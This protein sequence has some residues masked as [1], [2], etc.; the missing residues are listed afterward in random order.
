MSHRASHVRP[1]FASLAAIGAIMALAGAASTAQ[2]GPG[3]L[4]ADTENH[5]VKPRFD[6]PAER[7]ASP[8][9]LHLR[10]AVIDTAQARANF[11]A[12]IE[13][14]RI[15]GVRR[16]IQLDGPMTKARRAQL[17]AAGL[18]IGAYVPSNAF[19]VSA[20]EADAQAI[21]DIDFIRWYGVY[22][23]DWKL[24]PALDA[25]WARSHPAAGIGEAAVIV[26]LFANADSD[27]FL[28]S[29]D[30]F[31]GAAALNGEM[32]GDNFIA[33]VV[34][35]RDD[36][37]ALAAMNSVAFIEPA[38]EP[39]YR[40]STTSW[41]IQSNT[42]GSEPLHANG[43]RGEGQVLGHMDGRVSESHCSF[44]D[45][46]APGPSHRK[47]I[48]YNTSLGS[49]THGT[50]TAAT[51]VGDAGSDNNT[52]GV[53]YE[54]KMVFNSTPFFSQTE[55][56]NRLQLHHDQGARV[57]S[58]SWGNDGSTAYNAWTRAIDI[59][60]HDEEDSL[61]AFAVTNLSSL[62]TPENAKN[63]LAVGASRDTPSQ[64]Q[65]CTGGQGPTSDGRRKP[66][67]YAPGCSTQSSFGSGCST[68]G[69]TGTSMACPAISGLGLLVRQYYTD[70]FYPGGDADAADAFTPTAA[71][72]KAT[73]IN[74]AQDMTGVSGF[75][76]NREGWGR[77]LADEALY[78]DGDD[79]TLLVTDIRNTSAEA[80]DT[81]EMWEFEF[82]VAGAGEQLRATMVFTDKEAAP[83]A[84]FAPVNDLNLELISPSNTTFRG[85][86]FSG[87]QSTT[88]GSADAINN[89][90]Q[91]HVSSPETG[92]WTA[93]VTAA[94]VNSAENQGFAIVITG[95]VAEPTVVICPTDLN[96][97]GVTDS[98]DLGILIANFD[99]R[100]PDLDLNG[101]KQI[102]TADLG[103]LIANFG[104]PCI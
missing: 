35:K 31:E 11:S 73:L 61:V 89:V 58:N 56:V 80:M 24:D 71:L 46:V 88:G 101:D 77:A 75:P 41:I 17:E 44:D 3:D 94:A 74:S 40:N 70:G 55:F 45:N 15:D 85:N 42:T 76:S 63:V 37:G 60:S 52:R 20:A 27:A 8:T 10:S 21:A 13:Q 9:A 14:A 29:L 12:E 38:L 91:V 78:F 43:L 96:G 62:K 103:I 81:G 86:V 64:N 59:F 1:R 102:D 26:S 51:A 28:K 49:D 4:G 90:E 32:A 98:A 79:R 2:V 48:A 100:N 50:H 87:G 22:Q 54:A 53:A 47:I 34:I 68:T 92:G 33:H 72:V 36:L 82:E 19:V 16:V 57:H 39:T 23:N 97:D 95:E 5:T 67:I 30:A 65:H 93:R 104:Q 6:G 69:L 99:T 83:S 66:E 84:S 25:D 18:T 7:G